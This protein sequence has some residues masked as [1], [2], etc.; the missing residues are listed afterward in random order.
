MS[1]LSPPDDSFTYTVDDTSGATSNIATV[2][3]SVQPTGFNVAPV[4]SDDTAS[5]APGTPVNVNVIANDSD[6]DGTIDPTTVTVVTPPGKGSAIPNPDGTVTFTP[7]ALFNTGG[8]D[9][10]TYTVDD[11]G[12]AT[13]NEATVTITVDVISITSALCRSDRSEWRVRGTSSIPGPGNT[14]TI[15]IGS[16]FSPTILGTVPVDDFGDWRFTERN[17]ANNCAPLISAESTA[18]ATL[19][20]VSVTVK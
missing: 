5:T 13:S 4:A 9:F 6:A 2:N 10:F 18:G 20:P 15:R 12:G 17:S 1:F 11:D 19:G 16:P 3:I 8:T 7:N 14:I